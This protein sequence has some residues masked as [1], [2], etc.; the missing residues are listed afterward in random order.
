VGQY[1]LYGI[2]EVILIFIGITLAVGFENSAEEKRA[3]ELARGLLIGVQQDLDANA[4]ELDGNIEIDETFLASLTLVLAH[5]DT[6]SAWPDSLSVELENAMHWSSPF[7]ST[8]GYEGLKQA[9]LHRVPDEELRTAIVRL[10]EGRY[11][12]LLGDHDRAMWE[13]SATVLRPLLGSEIVRTDKGGTITGGL[14]PR[15]YGATRERGALRTA[16]S[17]ATDLPDHRAGSPSRNSG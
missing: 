13:F 10:F 16:L 12:F 14:A 7:L 15:D 6:S 9:G 1:L 5:L 2:G 3:S 4:T 11:G 8:S 17:R